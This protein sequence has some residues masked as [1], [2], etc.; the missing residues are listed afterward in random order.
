MALTGTP[1]FSQPNLAA[2][3]LIASG[4]RTT[5]GSVLFSVFKEGKGYPDKPEMAYVK[6]R[7][8][9]NKE[10]IA[11]FE[12]DSLPAGSY[13]VALLHDENGDNRM[14]FSGLGLPKEGYGFSNNVMGLFGPPAL[15]KASVSLRAGERKI[16]R[17]TLRY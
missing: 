17:I 15:S 14:N 16:V 7:A 5:K 12:I 8:A 10:G 11:V 13:A 4:A 3:Q 2:I 6:G 1:L 9:I